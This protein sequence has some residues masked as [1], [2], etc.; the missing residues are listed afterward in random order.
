MAPVMNNIDKIHMMA[1]QNK[2]LQVKVRTVVTVWAGS[3]GCDR[4]QVSGGF[5]V[6]GKLYSLTL[7]CLTCENSSMYTLEHVHFIIHGISIK[8]F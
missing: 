4:K 3:V 2:R 8:T 6:L 1:L 5:Q 7:V